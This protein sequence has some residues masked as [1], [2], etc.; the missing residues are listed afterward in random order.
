MKTVFLYK[1]GRKLF[2]IMGWASLLLI[3]S[4]SYSQSLT[5]YA[6]FSDSARNANSLSGFF[7]LNEADTLN[8]SQ[9]EVKVGFEDGDTSAVYQIFDFDVFS[10]LPYGFSYKREKN[11]ITLGVYSNQLIWTYY[12][13]IRTKSSSGTWSTPFKFVT[14]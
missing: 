9:L 8:V 3:C 14:N 5:A 1:H 10:G 6:E 4:Q 12:C 2:W 13:E 7:Y 11:I